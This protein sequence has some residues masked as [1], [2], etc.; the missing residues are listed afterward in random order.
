MVV[1]SVFQ[2]SIQVELAV[3][4]LEE[5]GVPKD[6][7]LAVPIEKKLRNG[8][9]FD[10]M[11]TSTGDS[12]FDWPMIIGALLMLLGCIYG[13]VLP[14]GPVIWGTIGAA[15][16]F[17]LGLAVK[18][19]RLKKK[20]AASYENEVVIAVSCDKNEADKFR[21][22]LMNNGALGVSLAGC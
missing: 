5:E 16:G 4:A 7:I 11:H 2:Q 21:S 8:K 6:R 20:G 14:W 19:V 13:F 22:L 17:G 3:T 15:A 12:M 1:M 9:L 10:T 18:I